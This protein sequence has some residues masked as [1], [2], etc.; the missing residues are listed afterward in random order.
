MNIKTKI[1]A[2]MKY[3]HNNKIHKEKIYKTLLY[4][5]ILP[6]ICLAIRAIY[7]QI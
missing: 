5:I 6:F 3:N 1:I 2:Y 7:A 4:N